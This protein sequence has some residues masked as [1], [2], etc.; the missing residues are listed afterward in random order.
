MDKPNLTITLKDFIY[1]MKYKS[2][3]KNSVFEGI[4]A[5]GNAPEQIQHSS[6]FKVK[7]KSTYRAN[8]M[9]Y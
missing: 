6:I 3:T 8:L 5:R 4:D 7:I 2:H 9:R 1:E